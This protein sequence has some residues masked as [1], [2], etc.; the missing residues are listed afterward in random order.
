V[1]AAL[2]MDDL[3]VRFAVGEGL[4]SAVD[5][6]SLRVEPGEIVGLVGESGCGK[7]TLAAAVMGLL[8]PSTSVTGSVRVAGDEVVGLDDRRLRAMRG[9]RVSMVVQDPS[10][11]LDP[12]FSVGEQVAETI[13]A[14][15]GSSGS[16]CGIPRIASS[17]PTRDS[18]ATPFHRPWPQCTA[19]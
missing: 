12:T 1:T 6:V 11:S 15:S 13:R 10:T 9:D 2:Q 3:R 14:S 5:G 17:R 7:S 16:A 19:W 18:M 8:P 4:V